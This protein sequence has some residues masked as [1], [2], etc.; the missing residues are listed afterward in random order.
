MHAITKFCLHI[1]MRIINLVILLDR[2]IVFILSIP[3]QTMT[4]RLYIQELIAYSLF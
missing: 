1:F 2:F 4:N 3:A